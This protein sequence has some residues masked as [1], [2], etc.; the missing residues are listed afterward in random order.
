MLDILR[1]IV[2]KCG[3]VA[4]ECRKTGLSKMVKADGTAVTQADYLVENMIV[5]ELSRLFPSIA[6]I[7]E[8]GNHY[9]LLDKKIAFVVDPIDGT[10]EYLRGGPYYCINIALVEYNQP[11]VGIIY[12]PS[13]GWLFEGCN[14]HFQAYR[15]CD[16][17][18][19]PIPRVAYLPHKS[20]KIVGS[21]FYRNQLSML[22][23]E[24]VKVHF[25]AVPSAVKFGLIAQSLADAY[26]CL[27]RTMIWD[28][29]AGQAIL[30]SVNGCVLSVDTDTRLLYNLTATDYVNQPF[31]AFAD[32][33]DPSRFNKTLLMLR[34]SLRKA[35]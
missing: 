33:I 17:D 30:E 7:S 13:L 12:A 5:D 32:H 21:G 27:G 28:S 24:G 10:K 3:A 1:Q 8:E 2:V 15:V 9:A 11:T 4:V 29:A 16:G 19:Y 20:I 23:Y 35:R 14:N 22:Q 18:L 31:G 26:F 6:V 25:R 34:D